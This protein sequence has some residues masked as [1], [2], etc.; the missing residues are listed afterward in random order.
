MD[1]SGIHRFRDCVKTRSLKKLCARYLK[2]HTLALEQEDDHRLHFN[3]LEEASATISCAG[4]GTR[5]IGYDSGFGMRVLRLW[6]YQGFGPIR[7]VL[8]EL[9]RP[10]VKSVIN[11]DSIHRRMADCVL[12]S[13]GGITRVRV[14]MSLLKVLAK[15]S[16]S[17]S[18]MSPL[19]LRSLLR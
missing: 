15:D 19:H 8:Q 18:A 11:R 2:L 10:T 7:L 13:S 12:V 4:M 5:L 16:V 6:S 9:M 1:L 3:G 14:R 17:L